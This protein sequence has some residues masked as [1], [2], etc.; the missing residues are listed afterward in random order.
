MNRIPG[1]SALKTLE[2]AGRLLS[3][4]KAAGELG[5]TP[6]AVSHQIRE[7]EDQL[8]LR[9]FQ[10]T[11]RSMRHTPAGQMLHETVAE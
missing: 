4:T 10:R 9:L 8:G 6:A 11:S 5:V 7:L 1:L 3:F 2:A